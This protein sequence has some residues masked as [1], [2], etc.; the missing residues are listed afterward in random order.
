MILKIEYLDNTNFIPTYQSLN[1]THP[2]LS[3]VTDDYFGLLDDN[4][5]EFNNDLVDIGIG[6][7]SCF[8]SFTSKCV[9]G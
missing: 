5:G 6:K 1:S 2:T 3:Y 9:S 4:E 7:I 8:Y